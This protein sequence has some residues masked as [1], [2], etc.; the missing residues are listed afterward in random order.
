MGN[1]FPPQVSPRPSPN[2]PAQSPLPSPS[3]MFDMFSDNITA[4]VP[5]MPG[6][7]GDGQGASRH[8]QQD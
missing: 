2:V 1:P 3:G 4:L 7:K 6:S 5:L 8:G